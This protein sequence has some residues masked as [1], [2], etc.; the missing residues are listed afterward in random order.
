MAV[1]TK[2]DWHKDVLEPV[3]RELYNLEMKNKTDYIPQLYGVENSQ[4][5][6]ESF[7]GAGNGDLME[8]WGRSNNQVYY[9]EIEEL[10]EKRIKMI[11][12]ST[13]REIERDFV[14]DLKLTEI[15]NRITNMADSVWK[16]QQYQA[17]EYLNNAFETTS[18]IDY[19]GRVYNAAGPD[20]KALC[21]TD[22]PYSPTNSTDVQSNKGSS[23]LSIDAWD[24]TVVAMQS[25][26]DNRGNLMAVMPDTLIVHPYN[27]RK[28]FQIAG[29]PGKEIPRYE[30]DSADYNINI[31]QGEI[32]V[33]V[34]PFLRNRYNWFAADSSRLKQLNKWF[35]RRKPD[36][37]SITDFD[38]EV[39][40]FKTVGRW[41][42]GFIN[43]SFIYGHEVSE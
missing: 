39:A 41:G 12:Y 25:W 33:I 17:V 14:D 5:D 3:F 21:A 7:D 1:I 37:G 18:A 23:P 40:K 29:M 34:N 4:K 20:G 16:T 24:D 11:K 8:E 36:N 9:D 15:K 35:W 43:Y 26:V 22:H 2:L 13:G 30:P 6:T 38:K 31:Y 27:R 28:A 19:R 42:K 10:W 32:T